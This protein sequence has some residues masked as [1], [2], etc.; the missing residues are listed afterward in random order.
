MKNLYTFLLIFGMVLLFNSS[1]AQTSQMEIYNAN[2]EMIENGSRMITVSTSNSTK[3][4]NTDSIFIRN[5]SEETIKLKVRKTEIHMPFGSTSDFNAIN[6]HVDAVESTT[7][8]YFELAPGA[9]LPDTACFKGT[10]R[11]YKDQ[12][13]GTATINYSF[14]SVDEE[15]NV[16]DSVYVHYSFSTT[17]VTP[18]D[19]VGNDLYFN[20]VMVEW[21]PT[22]VHEFPI[23]LNNHISEGVSV[24][25]LK[26]VNAIE[27]GQEFYFSFGGVD[28]TADENSSNSTGVFI[29]AGTTLTGDNG[30]VCK[31]DAKGIDG[32]EIL[33]KV[34]YKIFNRAEGNDADFVTLVYYL[35]GVGFSELD[36]FDISKPYPNPASHMV[37]IN[38]Q[39][40]INSQSILKIYN[41]GG[42][43][44]QYQRVL[45]GSNQTQIDVSNLNSGIYF[46]GIEIDGNARA[47]EKLIIE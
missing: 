17:S 11:P 3:L 29:D 44:V 39:L 12:T 31:F 14:L 34:T 6:Q 26:T 40:D 45:V 13:L 30:F 32:N 4:L 33:P 41:E 46:L 2:N 47:Y 21:D 23:D 36:Q 20:E 10:Y 43:L 15:G 27:E 25:V 19:S 1:W 8:L 24:R 22:I 7:P 9:T 42:Q 5:A 38:H 35:S 16:L 28:Y 18:F 37:T